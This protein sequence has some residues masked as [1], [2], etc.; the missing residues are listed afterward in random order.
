MAQLI[1]GAAAQ[2]GMRATAGPFARALIEAA[3]R[4]PEIVGVTADVAKYTDMQAFAELFPERFLNVGMAEQNLIAVAAGLAKVGLLPIATAFG[5]F[6][7]RRAHDFTV[8]QVALPKANIKLIGAVPGITSTFGPSH[9]SFDDL[10]LMRV[11]PNMVVIDPSDAAELGSAVTAS[12]EID[13]PVYL[14]QPFHREGSPD[15]QLARPFQIGKATLLK[16]GGDVGIVASGVMVATALNTAETMGA[17]GVRV[18]VLK[19]STLKPFD[20]EAVAEFA[21]RNRALVTAENHSVIGGLFSA[22]AESLARRGIPAIIEPLGVQ[23]VFPPFGS[24]QYL[25]RRLGMTESD[26]AAAAERALT[27]FEGRKPPARTP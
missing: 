8:M 22:T 5:V 18:G 25:R 2:M 20:D 27:R 13:G 26:L 21:G 11:I 16:E 7:T 23:D 24:T 9:T 14:R 17:R 15:A 3:H 19:V 12:L 6:T 4:W 1:T 10:A